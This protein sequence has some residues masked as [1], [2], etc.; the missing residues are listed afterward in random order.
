MQGIIVTRKKEID[1]DKVLDAAEA[2][3][4]RSGGRNFTLDAVAE[5]AGISKGG[6]VYTFPTKDGLIH[7]VLERELG[8]FQEAVHRRL[9]NRPVG[10]IQ[11]ALAHIE[12]ALSE[13]D[14][15]TQMAAFLV[16]ALVHAPDML[17]TVR[18]FYRALLD[19]FRSEQGEFAAA[20]HALLAV[21]GIFLLSG[22]GFAEVSPDEIK[23]VLLHARNSVLA[24]LDLPTSSEQP[25]NANSA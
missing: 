2:V 3:I 10:P 20:R 17:G 24:V 16:T 12:E 9:G 11:L 13:D 21:E 22:L 4:R 14:A 18:N 6:L 8:R 19:P 1:R 7:S 5:C 25:G 23:S 15:S